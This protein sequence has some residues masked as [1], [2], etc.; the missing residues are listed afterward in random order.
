MAGTAPK[1]MDSGDKPLT[2]FQ[3][4]ELREASEI[5]RDEMVCWS[6]IQVKRAQQSVD[7]F[8]HPRQRG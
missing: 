8:S 2:L 3:A 4:Q 7:L 1:E 6:G 5:E